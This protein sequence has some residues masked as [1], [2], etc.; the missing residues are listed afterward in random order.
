M[1]IVATLLLPISCVVTKTDFVA[2]ITAE[3]I[4]EFPELNYFEESENG[5]NVTVDSFWFQCV[6]DYK[7]KIESLK[8]ILK[9]IESIKKS[10]KKINHESSK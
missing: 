5:E 7:L 10:K 1:C 6:A 4:P 2:D 8:E 3:D 9:K